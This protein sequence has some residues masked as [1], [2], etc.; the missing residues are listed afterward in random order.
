M[1]KEYFFTQQNILAEIAAAPCILVMI[2]TEFLF[3][4]VVGTPIFTSDLDTVRI[5]FLISIDLMLEQM[6]ITLGGSTRADVNPFDTCIFQT[7][8]LY[9]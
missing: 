5:S 7:S 2:L 4:G 1:L 9:R 8:K 6:F 3:A